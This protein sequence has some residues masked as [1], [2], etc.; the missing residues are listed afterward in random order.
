[1]RITQAEKKTICDAIHG[2]DPEARIF[3]FGSRAD[4][5]KRGGDI[6]IIVL[7]KTLSPAHKLK[8]KA[9]IFGTLD[10]QKID[11]V[12]SNNQTDA[13]VKLILRD[14]IPL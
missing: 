8:I 3:L 1:M 13:F 10:E 14:A 2:F 7:S 12:I 11:I 9:S 5:A 6:D 4:D